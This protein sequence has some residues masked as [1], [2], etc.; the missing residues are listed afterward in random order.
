MSQEMSGEG[1]FEDISFV[2]EDAKDDEEN[3]N[4]EEVNNK[5]QQQDNQKEELEKIKEN[6]KNQNENKKEEKKLNSNPF[7]KTTPQIS[8]GTNDINLYSTEQLTAL[9]K[10]SQKYPV[11]VNYNRMGNR[12]AAEILYQELN[13]LNLIHA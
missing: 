2:E 3:K 8:E 10:M 6:E 7:S 11:I 12:R 13:K 9:S 1:D 4:K 5:D